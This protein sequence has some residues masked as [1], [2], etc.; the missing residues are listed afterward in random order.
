MNCREGQIL[1][2]GSPTVPPTGVTAPPLSF[3]LSRWLLSYM[4]M[5]LLLLLNMVLLIMQVNIV[6]VSSSG[7]VPTAQSIM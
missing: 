4:H 7:S 1:G 6:L 5:R 3:H 2:T